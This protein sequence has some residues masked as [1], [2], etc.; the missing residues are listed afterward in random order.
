MAQLSTHINDKEA[1][2]NNAGVLNDPHFS[3][4]LIALLQ[5]LAGPYPEQ[6]KKELIN[7]G[8][9]HLHFFF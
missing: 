4:F 5:T 2:V 9:N 1:P 3:Y 8:I 6:K 7:L